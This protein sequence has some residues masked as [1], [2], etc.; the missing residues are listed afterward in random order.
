[1]IWC[2]NART[3][4]QHSPWHPL[5]GL[6]SALLCT[7]NP[8]LCHENQDSTDGL[9]FPPIRSQQVVIQNLAHQKQL[10]CFK[11]V[12]CFIT[13][14]RMVGCNSGCCGARCWCDCWGS[15]CCSLTFSRCS[16]LGSQCAQLLISQ[17]HPLKLYPVGIRFRFDNETLGYHL[18]ILRY[19]FNTPLFA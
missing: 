5:K 9:Q 10:W 12:R 16:Q 2:L 8:E 3:W 15:C 13:D 6:S 19:T 7:I 18:R 14:F 4:L 17:V 11:N 1:M